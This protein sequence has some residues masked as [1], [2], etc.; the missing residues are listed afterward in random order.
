MPDAIPIGVFDSG[1]GG[2]SI[3]RCLQRELPAESF[4]YFAD[5]K[6]SP[7]GSKPAYWLEERAEFIAR[8]LIEQGCK[9]LVVAC[10]TATVNTIVALRKKIDVPIIGVEPAIK[11][12]ALRSKTGVVGVLA[13][14]QTLRAAS[15]RALTNK[16]SGPVK[17]VAQ[18]CPELVGLVESANLHSDETIETLESYIEPLL[19]LG[20]DH[21][22]LGCT[23]FSFLHESMARVIGGRA[24]IVEVGD[25]VAAELRRQLEK[26]DLLNAECRAGK[27]S[28]FSSSASPLGANN[29]SLLWGS[30]IK[31]LEPI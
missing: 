11:P 22:V 4:L 15:F 2:L 1:V 3:T 31:L 18:A 16:F 12:A 26:C 24:V 28:F 14:A 10:N 21:I 17:L 27:I 6:Y 20:A 25:S 30:P 23:H 29:M 9:A 5:Q 19:S 13:T 8:F 7:Y